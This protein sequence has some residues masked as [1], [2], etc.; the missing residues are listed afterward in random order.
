MTAPVRTASTLARSRGLTVWVEADLDSGRYWL[1][2]W[3]ARQGK[4]VTVRSALMR[5]RKLAPPVKFLEWIDQTD[6]SQSGGTAEARF[7]ADGTAES[8]TVKIGVD[9]AGCTVGVSSVTGRTTLCEGLDANLIPA[10]RIDLD[11]D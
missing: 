11:D 8:T 9:D 10:D 4:R 6:T 1:S 2:Y 7:S 3:S 5:P